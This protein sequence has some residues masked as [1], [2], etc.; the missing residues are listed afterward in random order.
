MPIDQ[1]RLEFSQRLEFLRHGLIEIMDL[2]MQFEEL[3]CNM[4]VLP[5]QQDWDWY[6]VQISMS[7]EYL[8]ERMNQIVEEITEFLTNPN[9]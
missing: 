3:R 5:Y 9:F 1:Q 7:V 6:L 4:S 8:K 2:Y